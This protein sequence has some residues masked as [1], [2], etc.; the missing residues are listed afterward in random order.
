MYSNAEYGANSSSATAGV[1]MCKG[2]S[3]RVM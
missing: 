1:H 3:F 2:I